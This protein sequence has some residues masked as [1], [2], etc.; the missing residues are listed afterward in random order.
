ML[1]IYLSIYRN[2]DSN[3]PFPPRSRLPASGRSDGRSAM[4]SSHRLPCTPLA[5][6]CLYLNGAL[7]VDLH[8]A[9]TVEDKHKRPFWHLGEGFEGTASDW[10]E[11][12]VWLVGVIGVLYYM[13]NPNARRNMH[14]VDDE[15][16]EHTAYAQVRQNAEA[17]DEK[18]TGKKPKRSSKAD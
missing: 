4:P 15:H 3:L 2:A 17:A 9:A 5:S 14:A 18:K 10:T 11:Y 7:A 8:Q 1:S 6:L 13:F 12:L 16:T